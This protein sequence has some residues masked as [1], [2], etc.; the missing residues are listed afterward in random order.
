MLALLVGV[1]LLAGLA[2]GC[3]SGSDNSGATVTPEDKKAM[4]ESVAKFF[5]AQGALDIKGI[6]AGIYDPEN[7]FGVATMTVAPEG[8]QKTEIKFAWSG[9]TVLL[10]IPSQQ[11]SATLSASVEQTNVVQLKDP[12][13]QGQTFVMKKDGGVWKIDVTATTKV[14]PGAQAPSSAPTSETP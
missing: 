8:A 7:I 5:V 2:A 11:A 1:L 12:A 3:K 13:G 9:D 6:K 10:T 4:V 14:A